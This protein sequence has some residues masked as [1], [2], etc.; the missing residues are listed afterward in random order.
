MEKVYKIEYRR[1]RELT[2]GKDLYIKIYVSLTKEE[3]ELMDRQQ[4][5]LNEQKFI[6]WETVV[7][8]ISYAFMIE[9][10]IKPSNKKIKEK[11]IIENENEADR[12]VL[13]EYMEQM[14]KFT[15]EH[16]AKQ[17]KRDENIERAKKIQKEI[18]KKNNI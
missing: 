15:E 13:K 5:Q 10:F 8:A 7:K 16:L 1:K 11:I 3:K 14:L 17:R 6:E 9:H 18:D 12:I 4:L 2:K